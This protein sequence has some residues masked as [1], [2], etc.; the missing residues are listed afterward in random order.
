MQQPGGNVTAP[1]LGWCPWRM[2]GSMGVMTI[3][4]A[5]P[6]TARPFTVADLDRMPD[7]GAV[8]SWSMAC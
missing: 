8:M 2:G 1:A 7:D 3:A 6:A 5:W 4:E